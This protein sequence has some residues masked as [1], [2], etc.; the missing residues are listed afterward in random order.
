M[1]FL[2]GTRTL[3][4]DAR[5]IRLPIHVTEKLNK[6]KKVQRVLKQELQRNPNEK[7]LADKLEVT[8]IQL[9]Q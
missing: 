4:N 5:I 8:S 2:K 9:R 6:L 3:A 7:E 1:I